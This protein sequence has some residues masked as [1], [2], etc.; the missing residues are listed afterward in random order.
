MVTGEPQ[1]TPQTRQKKAQRSNPRKTPSATQ[2]HKYQHGA[3]VRSYFVFGA[4]AEPH[5][6]NL[7]WT[8]F[9]LIFSGRGGAN[10]IGLV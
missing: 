4:L 8:G 10:H 6:V 1:P 2:Q 3:G 9:S 7:A 5:M